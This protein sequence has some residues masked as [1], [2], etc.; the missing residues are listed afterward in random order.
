MSGHLIPVGSPRYRRYLTYALGATRD[1]LRLD[2][3]ANGVQVLYP[4]AL[5]GISLSEFYYDFLI[6]NN[7]IDVLLLGTSFTSFLTLTG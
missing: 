4:A 2:S 6:A 7:Q 1:L 5:Y 3:L